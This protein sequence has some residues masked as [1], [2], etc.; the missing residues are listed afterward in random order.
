METGFEPRTGVATVAGVRPDTMSS[1]W[2]A[3]CCNSCR[4]GAECVLLRHT[5]S[6][7]LH[8]PHARRRGVRAHSSQAR[9]L[10]GASGARTAVSLPRDT[11]AAHKW[12][13]PVARASATVAR[14]HLRLLGGIQRRWLGAKT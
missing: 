8:A 3:R 11:A 2:A 9:V 5:S 12:R 10:F 7:V 1:G 14:D 6:V 4:P 13:I